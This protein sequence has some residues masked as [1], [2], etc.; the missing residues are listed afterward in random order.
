VRKKEVNLAKKFINFLIN[1]KESLGFFLF[2]LAFFVFFQFQTVYGG[3][4]G[5]FVSTAA[6]WSFAHPPGYPLFSLI[7]GVFYHFIP[8]GTPAWRVAFL[9]SIPAAITVLFF[10]RLLKMFFSFWVS[11]ISSLFLAFLYPFWFYSEVAEVFSLNNLFIVLLTYFTFKF[12]KLKNDKDKTRQAVCF[13]LTLGFAFSHH[14]TIIFLLPAL[15]IIWKNFL[16]DKK[17]WQ[18]LL[19]LLP[20]LLF[21]LYLPISALQNPAINWG[22]P[23]NLN[24]FFVV[25]FRRFYG[26]FWASPGIENSIFSRL[27]SI[28]AFLR[29]VLEDFRLYGI[30]LILIGFVIR[31][32][33]REKIIIKLWLFS[34][35]SLAFYIF[36]LFYAGFRLNSDF[37]V[38]TFERF[39]IV[40]YIFLVIFISLA[41]NFLEKTIYNHSLPT[42]RKIILPLFYFAF[43]VIFPILSLVK[44]YPKIEILKNDF[45]AE[46]FAKDLLDTGENGIVIVSSDTT[47][48]D[49]A[50]VYYSLKYKNDTIIFINFAFLAKNYYQKY[51]ENRYPQMQIQ[52]GSEEKNAF[53]L[54]V[55]N[56]YQYLPVYSFPAFNAQGFTPVPYGLLYRYYKDDEVPSAEEVININDQLW[57]KYHSPLSGSLGK[58]KN[59]FLADVINYYYVMSKNLAEYLIGQNKFKEAE[60][61]L[62]KSL[63]YYDSDPEAHL[64]LG[65]VYLETKR[66]H[67]AEVKFNQLKDMMPNNPFPDAYLRQVYLDCYQDEEKANQFLD[68]CLQKERS[69]EPN[70][71]ELQ[72]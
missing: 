65:R 38:A 11:L 69:R 15:F 9:A 10:F 36:L 14:H 34:A 22:N 45:T 2:L 19:L 71:E 61:Y 53:Q 49:S 21:Y 41:L 30:I 18:F 32:K 62:E 46:N 43:F 35:V 4:V 13:F 16:K 20:G 29:F 60:Q 56:N 52:M 7:A 17:N 68:S 67:E 55:E 6:V 24:N 31:I 40:P 66:C 48:F 37:G 39:M 51:L 58:Y 63:S 42:K 44:N 70:L 3:D 26:T 12:Y 54:L 59:L 27:F 47:F 33:L 1:E 23:V 25:F 5:D 28:L 50:Y 64:L 8:L 57:Q 72:N